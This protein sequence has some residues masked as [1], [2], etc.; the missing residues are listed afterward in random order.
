MVAI[1]DFS[2]QDLPACLVISDAAFGQG[3]LVAASFIAPNDQV[4]VADGAS[5]VVGFLVTRRMARSK[6]YESAKL[7]ASAGLPG[8]LMASMAIDPDNKQQGVGRALMT[9]ALSVGAQQGLLWAGMQAWKTAAGSI[10]VG[11]LAQSLGF[12]PIAES[13]NHWLSDPQESGY[14]CSECGNAGCH[15]SA[16]FFEKNLLGKL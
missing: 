6:F 9:H 15:C 13:T 10:D 16:V 7:E 5:G 12:K 3:C 8:L 2:P 1:R 4:Y 14:A 11:P